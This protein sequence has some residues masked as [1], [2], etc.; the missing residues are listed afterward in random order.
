MAE[1]ADNEISN[2]TDAVELV[3]SDIEQDDI[4]SDDNK[5][6][7]ITDDEFY[8]ELMDAPPEHEDHL[9]PDGCKDEIVGIEHLKSCL[10]RRYNSCPIVFIGSLSDAL[11]GAFDLND[12]KERRPLMIYVNNDNSLYSNLFCRQLLCNDKI[13]DYLLMNYVLWAWDVTF[14]SNGQMLNEMYKKAFTQITIEQQIGT[15]SAEHYPLLLVVY[16]SNTGN[17]LF[18]RIIVGSTKQP[19]VDEFLC[20]L[21]EAKDKFDNGEEAYARLKKIQE[22][23]DAKQNPYDMYSATPKG[24]YDHD[25]HFQR[26]TRLMPLMEFDRHLPHGFRHSQH[27]DNSLFSNIGDNLSNTFRQ[28]NTNPDDSDTDDDDDDDGQTPTVNRPPPRFLK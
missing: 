19:V 9:I 7:D 5:S 2:K 14:E 23:M 1:K 28:L 24:R 16:R 27:G 18:D 13:I 22:E 20:R 21:I 15:E 3:E 12:I 8:N 11:K 6:N 10:N 25:H 4:D 26:S 17:Y